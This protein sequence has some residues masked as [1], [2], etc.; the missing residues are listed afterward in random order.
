MQSEAADDA[1]PVEEKPG[2]QQRSVE[3]QRFFSEKDIAKHEI[4]AICC[5]SLYEIRWD[6][7]KA[8]KVKDIVSIEDDFDQ[9][10]QR[11]WPFTLMEIRKKN[12]VTAVRG[13]RF[14]HQRSIYLHTRY[15][16]Q[17]KKEK[18]KILFGNIRNKWSRMKGKELFWG[19]IKGKK[20][21]GWKWKCIP[22]MGRMWQRQ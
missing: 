5:G 22:L 1:C 16:G 8:C 18:V 13:T 6:E 12:S 17:D 7:N 2:K 14:R 11:W 21:K 9:N 15:M 19:R 4:N 20:I 10:M 3:M